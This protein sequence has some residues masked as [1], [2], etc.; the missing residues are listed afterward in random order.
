MGQERQTGCSQAREGKEG[1]IQGCWG[2]AVSWGQGK[3]AHDA[4][5]QPQRECGVVM[6]VSDCPGTPLPSV[7]GVW[8]CFWRGKVV[9][10]ARA[11]SASTARAVWAVRQKITSLGFK[12]HDFLLFL[13]F[14]LADAH[15]CRKKKKK[16]KSERFLLPVRYSLFEQ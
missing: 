6:L 2:T 9:S 13:F 8:V 4:Q 1:P 3:W 14:P 11:G 5:C 15:V 10:D 7:L 16:K 12:Y